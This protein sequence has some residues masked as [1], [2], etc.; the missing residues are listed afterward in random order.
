MEEQRI[1]YKRNSV[2]WIAT[3]YLFGTLFLLVYAVISL[4]GFF[5]DIGVS[6]V[7]ALSESSENTRLRQ[8]LVE[9]V[10]KEVELLGYKVEQG[11][12][13]NTLTLTIKNNSA[14]SLDNFHVE[15]AALDATGLP[16]YTRNEWLHDVRTVFPGDTAHAKVDLPRMAGGKDA[17]YVVRIS[18]FNVTG[19]DAVDE[20]C[21]SEL[22]RENDAG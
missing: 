11:A 22:S 7:K 14:Y 12:G 16:S 20:Y 2:W 10:R 17:E 6:G 4:L 19:A 18:R 3:C 13:S 9:K 1:I 15:V 21:K 5:T 8:S